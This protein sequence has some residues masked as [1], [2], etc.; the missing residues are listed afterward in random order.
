MDAAY[1]RAAR[2]VLN[3]STA[4]KGKH[5]LPAGM[6]EKLAPAEKRIPSAVEASAGGN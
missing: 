5:G 3:P 4:L 2:P 6:T 1:R